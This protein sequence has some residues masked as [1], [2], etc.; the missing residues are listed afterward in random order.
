MFLGRVYLTESIE[1]MA[2]V[3][4]EYFEGVPDY[5]LLGVAECPHKQVFLGQ[6]E[7]VQ[8]SE[9]PLTLLLNCP[10]DEQQHLHYHLLHYNSRLVVLG[11]PSV[12]EYFQ[13]GTQ[14][15]TELVVQL[16]LQNLRV[17][18][19]VDDGNYDRQ[20][21]G[22]EAVL[23]Q[24]VL[25]QCRQ[26]FGKALLFVGDQQVVGSDCHQLS[27]RLEWYRLA[28]YNF[29]GYLLTEIDILQK[30]IKV[31]IQLSRQI[32]DELDE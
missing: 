22:G 5:M 7:S 15:S 32:T 16:I 27:N 1:E 4:F 29:L 8:A 21:V 10:L 11:Q 26:C 23:V 25:V 28:H 30:L 13:Q 12:I 31:H 2:M 6:F 9:Y 19:P 14:H 24:F 17:G 20:V 18:M 3:K